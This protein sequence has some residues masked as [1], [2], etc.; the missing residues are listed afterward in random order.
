MSANDHP[1]GQGPWPK[2]SLTLVSLQTS[3]YYL[4]GKKNQKD[5]L[6]LISIYGLNNSDKWSIGNIQDCIICANL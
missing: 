4:K 2:V 1:F 6:Q 3:N 5:D